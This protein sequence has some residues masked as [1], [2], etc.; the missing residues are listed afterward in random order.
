MVILSNFHSSHQP[1]ILRKCGTLTL[2]PG[3][4][5]TALQLQV[6]AGQ[7]LLLG[8]PLPPVY[9]KSS[10]KLVNKLKGPWIMVL[11]KHISLPAFRVVW[12]Q[13]QKY[14]GI[15]CLCVTN[16][17][18]RLI[19]LQCILST[20]LSLNISEFP[21]TASAF[22]VAASWCVLISSY[23][24]IHTPNSLIPSHHNFHVMFLVSIL[25]FKVIYLLGFTT[26][27]FPSS[28]GVVHELLL[29]MSRLSLA[30]LTVSTQ[31]QAWRELNS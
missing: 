30:V 9:K 11:G 25:V 29:S 2:W 4:L 31:N 18:L 21:G 1:A 28:S 17:P 14:F 7:G 13:L 3:D 10:D 27:H 20:E 22:L 23:R 12:E 19:L 8:F 26:L 5:A 6:P 15:V 16:Q 24:L